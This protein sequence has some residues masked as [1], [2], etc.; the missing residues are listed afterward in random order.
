MGSFARFHDVQYIPL[1]IRAAASTGMCIFLQEVFVCNADVDASQ[2]PTDLA[3]ITLRKIHLV[4]GMVSAPELLL[5]LLIIDHSMLF[6][7]DTQILS[8]RQ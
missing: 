6:V 5:L 8:P 2:F 1:Y 3:V 7:S 4:L